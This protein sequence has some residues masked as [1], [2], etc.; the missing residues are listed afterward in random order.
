[1]GASDVGIVGLVEG[2]AEAHLAINPFHVEGGSSVVDEDVEMANILLDLS[3]GLLDGCIIVDVDSDGLDGVLRLRALA[4]DALYGGGG[5]F[6][7][8]SSAENA[9]WLLGLK[10]DLASFVANTA[11][12]SGDEDD[13][14]SADGTHC[15]ES[16]SVADGVSKFGDQVDSCHELAE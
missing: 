16:E 5:L 8:T 13:L 15:A 2:V 6:V 14:S 7:G 9:V 11:I 10:E 3:D 12:A 4:L 1:M